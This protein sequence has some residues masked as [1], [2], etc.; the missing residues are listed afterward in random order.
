MLLIKTL[1]FTILAPG[2]LTVLFPYWIL[3][4]RTELFPK[5]WNVWAIIGGI[6][7]ML[8][9]S[10]YLFCAWEFISTGKGT[11]APYDPPKLLVKK[12]LYRFTRNP[13]YVGVS[14]I[15]LGESIYFRSTALLVY[16]LIV[17]TGFQLR[18]LF[19]EEPELKKQFGI[20]FDEYC[21]RV[22]RWFLISTLFKESRSAK[23]AQSTNRRIDRK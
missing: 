1:L 20:S 14:S 4:S 22:P 23:N 15:I 3:Q 19:Y 2:T 12:G 17:W 13:M 16:A 11:P 8:G 18:V 5:S 9:I 7:V 6:V 21:Q 10:I